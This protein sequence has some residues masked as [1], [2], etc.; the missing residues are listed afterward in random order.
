MASGRCDHGATDDDA[1]PVLHL[2]VAFPV[3]TTTSS[4]QSDKGSLCIVSNL[5]IMIR[6]W[7]CLCGGQELL[8][9]VN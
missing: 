7:K 6:P 5:S 9:S 4:S 1:R 8:D 2:Q 3:C